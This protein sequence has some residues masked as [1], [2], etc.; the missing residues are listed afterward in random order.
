MAGMYLLSENDGGRSWSSGGAM[1]VEVMVGVG[2][3]QNWENEG[4]WSQ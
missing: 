1:G 3:Y 4:E 2:V